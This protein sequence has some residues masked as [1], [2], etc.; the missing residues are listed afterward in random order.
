MSTGKKK[1]SAKQLI[2]NILRDT[3]DPP[4]RESLQ[5]AVATRKH[6]HKFFAMGNGVYIGTEKGLK[7][8][9]M[10]T[11]PDKTSRMR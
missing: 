11:G 4:K 1:G 5:P 10:T 2:T 8:F 6:T 3:V 7:H 9:R